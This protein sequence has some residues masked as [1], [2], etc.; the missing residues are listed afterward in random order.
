MPRFAANLSMMF[1]EVPFL[2]RFEAAAA[3]GFRGVEYL[4]PYDYSP[5]ELKERLGANGLSQVLFNLPPGDWAA[6]ERGLAA[7]PGRQ[8]DVR[9]GIALAIDYAQA[10]DCPRLHM[11]A[12]L[13]PDGA[14]RRECSAVYLE[15]LRH[16]AAEAGRA[17]LS[18]LL[19]PIN[20]VDMPGY[21]LN[22]Q[23][24]ARAFIEQA[25]ADNARVQLDFYHCQI[26]E[27]D[28][29]RALQRQWPVLGH[30]QIAGVPDRHEPD[31]GEVNYN[32]LFERLDAHGYDGW[33]GCEYR[34]RGDTVAGLGWAARW[35]IGPGAGAD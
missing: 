15:N 1:G 5:T 29:T 4:F 27:G 8:A 31:I 17:G 34:P 9:D 22:T 16:A 24:E 3:A 13:V 12:G 11:M 25:G 20:P 33:V 21:F 18:L 26:V 32:W 30:V 14:D 23:A 2:Q 19:E 10:L 28:L 35:G 6:G 7:I